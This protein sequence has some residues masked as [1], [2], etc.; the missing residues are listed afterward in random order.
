MMDKEQSFGERAV[1]LSFNPSGDA[2]VHQ[3]KEQ[4]AKFVDSCNT[5]REEATDSEVKRMYSVAITEA[6]TA[7][8]WSVKAATWRG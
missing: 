1:G 4:I 5:L 2:Y 6:R 8:M 3:L 7:Q